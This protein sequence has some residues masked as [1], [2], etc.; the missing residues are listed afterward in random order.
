MCR[1]H[2]DIRPV[3]DLRYSLLYCRIGCFKGQVRHSFLILV[4]DR[5]IRRT[6]T[7]DRKPYASALKDD[8]AFTC[9]RISV[10]IKDVCC[11]HWKFRLSKD[12]FHGRYAPVKL[13]VAY[14]HAIIIHG[15][16]CGHDRMFVVRRFIGNLIC[17]YRTLDLITCV[18]QKYDRLFLTDLFDIG[19]QTGHS[20]IICLFIIFIGIP[21][22]ICMHIGCRKNDGMGITIIL[23]PARP[24]SDH[25]GRC[26][27]CRQD[28]DYNI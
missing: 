21:P 26:N 15:I 12:L 1:H 9:D 6:D 20:V 2:Y 19:V 14:S 25:C 11:E 27:N 13:V 8:P 16:H 23:R 28:Q 22:D 7:Y 10:F 4:P 18:Y 5:N 17:H 3:T 24:Q